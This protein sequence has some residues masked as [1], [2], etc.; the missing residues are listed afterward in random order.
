MGN[1]CWIDEFFVNDIYDWVC[2][3]LK[4]KINMVE[5]V[6]DGDKFWIVVVK[7]IFWIIV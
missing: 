5:D 1:K 4:D 7:G 3:G 2:L 6:Y